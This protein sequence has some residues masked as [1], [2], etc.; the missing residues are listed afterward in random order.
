[1]KVIKTILPLL[2][3]ALLAASCEK[4]PKNGDLDGMWQLKQMFSKST[5]TDATYSASYKDTTNDSIYWNCQLDL[6]SIQ[7]WNGKTSQSVARFVHENDRLQLT[8]IYIHYRAND[9]LIEDPNFT[10]LR[11][12]G[13]R[14]NQ[15][16]YFVKRLNS[17]SMILC[18]EMDSLVFRKIH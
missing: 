17:S 7:T 3:I 14:G 5:S 10:G 16:N 9:V 12:A 13:I 2:L 6:I 18:S 1:M 8:K 4:K 11:H 15:A